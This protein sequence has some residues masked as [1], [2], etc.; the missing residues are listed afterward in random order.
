MTAPESSPSRERNDSRNP[1]R[2]RAL[3]LTALALAFYVGFIALTY[4]RSH[5]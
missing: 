2:I 3:A 4:H 5:H 1:I